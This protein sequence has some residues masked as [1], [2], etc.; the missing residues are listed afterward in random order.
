MRGKFKP[1][2]G[3]CLG[4]EHLTSSCD[5][6]GLMT[7]LLCAVSLQHVINAYILCLTPFLFPLSKKTVVLQE[8]SK[9]TRRLKLVLHI[10]CVN[11][12]LCL[13]VCVQVCETDIN[14]CLWNQVPSIS[15][16]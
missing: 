6:S 15:S 9:N 3:R 4:K 2:T 5:T 12:C 8:K 10:N 14:L 13:L 16:F 11:V 7:K 1:A